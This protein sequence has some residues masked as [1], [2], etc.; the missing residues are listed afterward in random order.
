MGHA[1]MENGNGLIVEAC[2]TQADGHGERTAALHMIEPRADR[3]QTITLAADKG[4]D[5]EDFV[6]ELRSMN[7]T[8][9]VA[10]N[11]SGR[12]SAIDGRATRHLGYA[13][14]QRLRKRIEVGFGWIKTVAGQSQ[15][16]FRRRDRGGW[17]FTLAAA[18][19]LARLL[20]HLAAVA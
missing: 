6:N 5:A 20:K 13:V 7:V 1:L 2:L 18:Y 11:T 15:T 9:Q 4:Y 12:S 19:D 17:S 16:K 10:Q 3:P 8:R 14:S